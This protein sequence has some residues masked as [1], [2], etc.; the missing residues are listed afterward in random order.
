MSRPNRARPASDAP[1][2]GFTLV[3]LVVAMT[4]L[5]VVM[6]AVVATV[7]RVQ[8]EVVRQTAEQEMQET[9]RTTELLVTRAL[10]TARA[11]PFRRGIGAIDPNPLNHASWDNVRATGDHN[12]AD[13]DL[14]D[15]LEDVQVYVR[16]DTLFARWQ[17]GQAGQFYA[18]PVRAILFEYFAPDGTP[19][20]LASQI[21]NAQR[22]RIRI[23]VPAVRGGTIIRRE[24]WVYLRN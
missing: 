22:V 5:A 4:L 8:R 3:E 15:P 1:R 9:L 17:A 2:S 21:D 12:P 10:R 19:V 11:D 24:T 16:H 7:V 20:T 13:G 18:H 6:G 14:S 23:D